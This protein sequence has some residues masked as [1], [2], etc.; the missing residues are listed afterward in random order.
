MK[1]VPMII[2]ART[3]IA[4]KT[5]NMKKSTQEEEDNMIK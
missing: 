3:S 4:N 1:K 5:I 2:K